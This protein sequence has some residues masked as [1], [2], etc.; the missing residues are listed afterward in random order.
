MSKLLEKDHVKN[1]PWFANRSSRINQR[2]ERI[3]KH[4][5]SISGDFSQK[6]NL[7]DIFS[8]A[9]NYG[10]LNKSKK[11][12][13]L[14]RVAMEVARESLD[15]LEFPIRPTLDY[16]RV[17]NV[18]SAGSS[19]DVLSGTIML[20]CKCT[21][22]MGTKQSFEIPVAISGGNVVPPSVI[23]FQGRDQVLAQ[24]T[25]NSIIDRVSSYELEPVRKMFSP[26][27]T[28]DERA[29]SS[30]TRN[31]IGYTAREGVGPISV[32]K[33]QYNKK[34]KELSDAA[35]FAPLDREMEEQGEVDSLREFIFDRAEQLRAE[36]DLSP[37]EIITKILGELD[38]DDSNMR[39][40]V[41]KVV[42][43]VFG[44]KAERSDGID[45]NLWASKNAS[46]N[47][48]IPPGYE[49]CKEL[50]DKA[51]EEGLD[52]FPR[53][54]IHVLRN[55]ILEVVGTASQDQWLAHLVNDGYVINP[56]G[57][58]NRGRDKTAQT[59]TYGNPYFLGQP[60]EYTTYPEKENKTEDLGPNPI[61][62]FTKEIKD[63]AQQYGIKVQGKDPVLD[64][65]TVVK[66]ST[67]P[68]DRYN[69]SDYVEGWY[70]NGVV[71]VTHITLDDSG[72]RVEQ[73]K[74]VLQVGKTAQADLDVEP[75]PD[76][77]HPKYKHLVMAEW[78]PHYGSYIVTFVGHTGDL[79][80][81]SDDV[82][83]MVGDDR[84]F[85]EGYGYVV[86]DY[87]DLLSSEEDDK[88]AKKVA[89]EDS[90]EESDKEDFDNDSKDSEE[91][92]SEEALMYEGTKTPIEIGDAVKFEGTD[93]SIRGT[94]VEIDQEL[95]KVIVKAKGYEYRV[96]IDDIA[97]LNRT[98]KKMYSNTIIQLPP[99]GKRGQ[100]LVD[101]YKRDVNVD[102][103]WGAAWEGYDKSPH[104]G[105][106]DEDPKKFEGLDEPVIKGKNAQAI[107][108][109]LEEQYS[110]ERQQELEEYWKKRDREKEDAHQ[111]NEEHKRVKDID[112]FKKLLGGKKAISQ[113]AKQFMTLSPE[114][115]WK[116]MED[117]YKKQMSDP[118]NEE[119]YQKVLDEIDEVIDARDL[120]DEMNE[121]MAPGGEMPEFDEEM[122]FSDFKWSKK[123]DIPAWEVE[124][125]AKVYWDH[126]HLGHDEAVN[127][128]YDFF[129]NI[130]K[131]QIKEAVQIA[132]FSDWS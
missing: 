13:D 81:S 80:M 15:Q 78:E 50:M 86:D 99:P 120:Y 57:S 74:E 115:L 89:Q 87:L 84:R 5:Q 123:A 42:N 20:L 93:K 76:G 77:R 83:S 112:P 130:S 116:K 14:I 36:E 92:V 9:D 16:E 111:L 21:T 95:N 128:V 98:F 58:N 67:S 17:R 82:L 18:K 7:N 101:M 105:P 31:E 118:E 100:Q 108:E 66:W 46:M 73:E 72:N 40:E 56:Y 22:K 53:S 3:L 10:L 47:T 8:N 85:D 119:K 102:N 65:S 96:E 104:S 110:N 132:A 94:I 43:E 69:D 90:E 121:F 75:G 45:T 59:T 37:K 12:P 117:L 30:E 19:D 63:W 48:A 55:Y 4:S 54:W 24:S 64:S 52:T 27:M 113:R 127:Y 122:D 91:D 71:E 26:L 38:T 35:F 33:R 114:E 124:K 25:I 44:S 32:C 106:K 131:Q 2:R 60:T 23:R 49:S 125:A 129:P 70:H 103:P 88:T 39:K 28:K 51:Q 34:A 11:L 126:S 97:P 68:Y 29:I 107:G 79:L 6:T 61:L 62:K 41:S 1:H 109:D